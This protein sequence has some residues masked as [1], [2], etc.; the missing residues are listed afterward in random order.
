MT[1]QAQPRDAF[2][3]FRSHFDQL[4]DPHHALVILAN[5][6]DWARFDVA[7]AACY[8]P[9]NGA[10]GKA[11]RL[12]VGL[13]YLK[14]T[15]NESDESVVARWVENPYWQYF[16]GYTHMQHEC[17][18]HPTALVKWRKRVGSDRLAELVRETIA[19]A[20]REKHLPT[21]DLERVNVD[22]TV[23]EKNITHPTDAKLLWRC[24]EKLVDAAQRRGIVLR[25]SYV[26]V[27]KRAAIKVSRY[28]HARQFRRMRRELRFLR[29]RVGRL[30]RDIK[31][32]APAV[33]IELATLLERAD[34][35]AGQQPKDKN[36]LYSLHE[37]E[38][39][40]I[41]KGK[42]HKRYEF[43]QKVAVA[44]TN[45]SNWFVAA[46][47][48]VGNPY[49]GHTLA[50]TVEAV[51]A[52]TGMAVL[53]AYVDKGYRGHDY[54]GPAT[55]HVAGSSKRTLTRS[56]RKRRRRRSAVE[57]KIGHAKSDH[58][59][60]RCFLQGLAG[61]AINATLTVAG[62]NLRKLLNLLC[63]ALTECVVVL[64]E[65]LRTQ[66]AWLR[67]A[68]WRHNCHRATVGRRPSWLSIT[69]AAYHPAA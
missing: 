54:D 53:D 67:R 25:Q 29:T 1:P 36:K 11:I 46:E 26:R 57:P 2:E 48:M 19:L 4:L 37:P 40:C 55:V 51:E 35:I 41:S 47:L 59:M 49:D 7:F 64:L 5:Q 42:A 20:V 24:M 62:A 15:F 61:D 66:L 69:P 68:A 12:M 6:I 33:D 21:K 34:R 17:P 3:L 44:T 60:G 58:R 45:R 18:L 52:N 22:T 8:C 50:A 39:R 14:Y 10:P 28:A 9:D 32:K 30:I 38:V 13:H 63:F 43:G 27:G 56:E 65:R 16:C 31:R 23:Q